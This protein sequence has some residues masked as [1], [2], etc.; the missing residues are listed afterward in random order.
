MRQKQ[1]KGLNL[2]ELIELCTSC[3]F[4]EFRAKQIYHWMYRHRIFDV[5]MMNNLPEEI[6][7]LIKSDYILK[8]LSIENIQIDTSCTTF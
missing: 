8:T 2:A 1:I 5:D 3:G 6:R 4:S 7:L